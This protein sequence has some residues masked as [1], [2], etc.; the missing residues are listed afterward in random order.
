MQVTLVSKAAVLSVLLFYAANGFASVLSSQQCFAQ[1]A[2]LYEQVYCEVRAAQPSVVLPSF[3][4]FKKNNSR[5]QAL[6]I[7]RHAERQGIELPKPV[8]SSKPKPQHLNKPKPEIKLTPK[9]ATIKLSAQQRQTATDTVVARQKHPLSGCSWVSPK[10]QCAERKFKLTGNVANRDLRTDVFDD[11]FK[12]NLP[13][14]T[15]SYT[16]S[17]AVQQYL[18]QAYDVYLQKMLAIGLGGVTMS[19]SKFAYF[20]ED[21][22]SKGVDF[23][24]RF[25]TMFYYLKMDKQNNAVS[26]RINVPGNFSLN[27][28]YPFASA[29]AC[30][31]G[32]RNYLFVQSS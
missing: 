26:G 27:A 3:V 29:V 11:A 21:L 24:S 9:R 32:G 14:Y 8:S 15:G 28:C 18:V 19:Y 22:H 6:L 31:S 25:E 7:K 12:L 17:R 30:D 10:I 13:T 20:F 5:M 4:D 16:N 1:A 2:T 23:N